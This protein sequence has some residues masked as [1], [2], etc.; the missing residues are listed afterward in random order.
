MK[1]THV[2][3]SIS[4]K[5]GGTSTFLKD[6]LNALAEAVANTLVCYYAEDA[7]DVSQKISIKNIP[8]EKKSFSA[9]TKNFKNVFDAIDTEVFHGNGLWDFPIHSMASYA[10]KKNRPYIISPHGML[11]PWSL[12]QSKLKKEI[13]LKL[14]QQKDL[15]LASCIHATA[16]SEL[17]N[18]RALG[19]EN[20]IAIIPNGIN[21]KEFPH[22]EKQIATKR[23]VLFL[24]R[25][26]A[27]KGIELLVRAWQELD[28][29]VTKDWEVEIV[30]NGDKQ[31][32][33]SLNTLINSLKL[34]NTI[35]ISEPV[36]GDAKLQK[37]Q[38]ASLF[39]LPTY[40]EN[41]GIVV[42]EALASKVPVITTKGTPWKELNAYHCGKW[43]EIGKDPLKAALQMM[44]SKS[45][46][47]LTEMGDNGRKLIEDKYSMVAVA[48][49]MFE[50]YEW[51]LTKKNKPKFVDIL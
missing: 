5:S 2:I 6:L 34:E 3:T 24:S 33:K 43:I 11:E 16:P 51:L 38:S 37:Y 46:E 30:G 39:V 25:I 4:R 19:Y 47:E 41:F 48:Q 23:K 32:I 35:T 40:S 13:A 8:L 36:F 21:L 15:R 12:T 31:Y 20:P 7:L 18:I 28:P 22:Y 29:V 14:Y 50:L 1:I 17:D 44:L 42:A 45:Q 9:Y 10:R 26:H 49:Q 27:K